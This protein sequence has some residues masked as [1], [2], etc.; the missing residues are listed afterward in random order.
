[1]PRPLASQISGHDVKTV[2]DMGWAGKSNGT[3]LSLMSGRFDVLITVDR[4][5]VFNADVS[6]LKVGVIVLHA[7]SNRLEDLEPLVTPILEAL[8][9]IRSGQVIHLGQ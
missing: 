3:L 9:T 5:L 7:K 8:E 6:G 4:N 2:Q 1:M